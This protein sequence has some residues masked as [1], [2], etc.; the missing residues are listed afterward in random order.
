MYKIEFYVPEEH[1]EKVKEAMFAAGAG[2]IGPY[3]HCAWE[4]L[5][6]GQFQ[7]LEGS[8]PFIG[9]ENTIECI[10]EYKVELICDSVCLSAV[11]QAM[12][13]SHPYEQPAYFIIKLESVS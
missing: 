4:I 13:S 6:R 3:S 5:G 12:K 8:N 1:L 7:P 10:H 11:I 2:R 9:K